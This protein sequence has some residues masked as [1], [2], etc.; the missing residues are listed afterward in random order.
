MSRFGLQGNR[1]ISTLAIMNILRLGLLVGFA[2]LACASWIPNARAADPILLWPQTAPGDKGDLGEEK[3]TTR[4]TDNLIA[5]KPVIRLGNVSKPAITV[6]KP[7][8]GKDTGAAV[9]VCPGGGYNILAMDLEGTEVC[10]WLNSIGVTGVLLKYRVPARKDRPKYEAALQDAQ[11]ALGI[12]RHNAGAWGID[13]KRIGMLGFS[14]GGHL[15]AAL[16][17]NFEKRIYDPIDEA[18]TESCRPD[19]AVVIYPGLVSIQAQSDK[20]A[21]EMTITTNTPPTILVQAEDDRVRVENSIFYYLALKNAKVPAEMHLYPK[22]GHGYGLRR[23]ADSVTTWPNRVEDWM[24][25]RHLLDPV[26]QQ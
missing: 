14:A 12:V 5:G 22:G 16:S 9:V 10:E 11:R 24:R 4:P 6:Y 20:L 25:A 17:N 7:S 13:P 2:T 26:L 8:K 15:T 18:D 19:F 1:G 23:T 21:P 3:D